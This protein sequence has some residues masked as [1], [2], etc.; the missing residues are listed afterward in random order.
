MRVVTW[1]VNSIRSRTRRLVG[2]VER[3]SPDVLLLQETKTA[4]DSLVI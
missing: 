3:N 4:D 2:W 1:N